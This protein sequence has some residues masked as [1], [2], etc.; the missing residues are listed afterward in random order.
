MKHLVF[1][2]AMV[3]ALFLVVGSSVAFSYN[4]SLTTKNA[5]PILT[6]A[7]EIPPGYEGDGDWGDD[8]STAMIILTQYFEGEPEGE[9]E[10]EPGE[11]DTDNETI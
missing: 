9:P 11:D 6:Q 10:P 5:L 1:V 2:V 8:N 3:L 4:K 7:E